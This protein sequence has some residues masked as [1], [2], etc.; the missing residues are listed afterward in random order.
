M[1]KESDYIFLVETENENENDDGEKNFVGDEDKD[2]DEDNDFNGDEDED[3]GKDFYASSVYGDN[4][5]YPLSNPNSLDPSWPK[6]YRDSVDLY[7]GVASPSLN[8]LGSSGL[9]L[10]GSFHSSSPKR[11][12]SSITITSLDSHLLLPQEHCSSDHSLHHRRASSAKRLSQHEKYP[13]TGQSSFG[14][15][16]LNGMCH[17]FLTNFTKFI[18]SSTHNM[19]PSIVFNK[20]IYA[21]C[22]LTIK[23]E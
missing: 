7:G 19:L 11:R 12:R 2:V 16:V 17:V 20:K 6:S 14:Q 5:P 18:Y 4:D 10:G 15:V 13:Q 9:S 8:F 22:V 1:E 3:N 21:L 23:M